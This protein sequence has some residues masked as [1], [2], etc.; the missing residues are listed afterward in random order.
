MQLHLPPVLEEL[1][2]L[3]TRLLVVSFAPLPRLQQWFPFFCDNFLEPYYTEHG[4]RFDPALLAQSRFVSDPGLSVYHAY[5]LGRNSYLKVY[6][7][8]ILW[9]YVKWAIQR[10][11]IKHPPQDPLQKG[12][13]F[14]VSRD[15]RLTFSH[16]GRDQ[17]DR[18]S[19]SAILDALK[20][21]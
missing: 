3:D 8:R 15:M 10:K 18:P 12:G 4:F 19:V 7:P 14:V 9:Q 5:G 13:D 11:P 6:G 20:A 1:A 21:S 16:V 17:A 2:R